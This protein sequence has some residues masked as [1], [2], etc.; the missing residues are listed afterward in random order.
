M[1]KSPKTNRLADEVMKRTSSMLV[2]IESKLCIKMEKVIDRG[3][4][5][6]TLNEVNTVKKKKKVR[7]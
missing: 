3:K 4:E 5:S 1:L 6:K 2:E 7:I